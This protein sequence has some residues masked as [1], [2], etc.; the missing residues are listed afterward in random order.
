MAGSQV[1]RRRLL[2]SPRSWISIRQLDLERGAPW[3]HDVAVHCRDGSL[4]LRMAEAGGS[5]Y[6]DTPSH[7]WMQTPHQVRQAASLGCEAAQCCQQ[8]L[9]M[10]RSSSRTSSLWQQKETK[11]VI[12]DACGCGRSWQQAQKR[13]YP[14]TNECGW[15]ARA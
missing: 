13:G 10:L 4:G 11:S 5:G 2:H 14:R 8:A 9:W 1:I 6:A 3:Q 15:R 12:C 7:V